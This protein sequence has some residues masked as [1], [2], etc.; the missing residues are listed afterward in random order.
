[1]T[2]K[3]SLIIPTRERLDYLPC[4]LNS[5]QLAADRAGAE[6]E[7]LVA[8]NASADGTADWLATQR[9]PRLKVIRS[10][11]RLS[12]RENFQFALENSTG[13]HLIYIGD[14]DAVLPH[15]LALARRMIDAADVD[16]FKW[17]VENY[18]WPD[19]ASGAGGWVKIRPQHLDGQRQMIDP[20]AVLDSFCKASFRTYHDGGMIYHGMISRR[21]IDRVVARTGGPYFRGSS[22]DLYTSMQALVMSDRPIMKVSLPLTMG[23][24]SPR[25]NGAA[26]QRHAKVAS[27]AELPEF[28]KFIRE[29]AEDPHQC[30]LPARAGSLNLV[31]LDGLTEAA[32]VCGHKLDLDMT[33]WRARVAGEI[34]GFIEPDRSDCIELARIFF[35]PDFDIPPADLSPQ[36]E[37]PPGKDRMRRSNAPGRIRAVGGPAMR[38]ALAAAD[39]LDRLTR[40]EVT[41]ARPAGRLTGFARM[42]R[43]H[44][45]AA[46]LFDS[47]PRF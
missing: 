35:G 23:G 31:T 22:P 40:L 4:A 21:L 7:I 24:T 6:V 11:R 26:A 16:I 44:G 41:A 10:E 37:A 12:M 19:P 43:M 45:A 30:R 47:P 15:G 25:S 8:D 36:P 39:F 34:S 20:G 13:S 28:A 46:R 18:H 17:R 29:S 32:R 5:A 33:A 9:D 38:D 27:S 1:M 2:V 42:L 14:D 3:I